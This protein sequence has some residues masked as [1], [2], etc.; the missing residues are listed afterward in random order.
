MKL[1]LSLVFVTIALL[2]VTVA[3]PM[4]TAFDVISDRS[5]DV[6]A[7]DERSPVMHGGATSYY[8]ADSEGMSFKLVSDLDYR[9]FLNNSRR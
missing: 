5:P 4:G 9:L 6:E 3:A 8:I 1:S 7:T 2:Q